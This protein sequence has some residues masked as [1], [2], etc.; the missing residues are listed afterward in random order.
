MVDLKKPPLV[1]HNEPLHILEPSSRET[2][3]AVPVTRVRDLI[4]VPE[5]LIEERKI[6][7]R[8]LKFTPAE[9]YHLEQALFLHKG[10]VAEL[11]AGRACVVFQQ[12][13]FGVQ[14]RGF[15]ALTDSRISGPAAYLDVEA[16]DVSAICLEKIE[17]GHMPLDGDFGGHVVV[18]VIAAVIYGCS[19]AYMFEITESRSLALFLG[20]LMALTAGYLVAKYGSGI[21]KWR[22][23]RAKKN[24]AECIV[25]EVELFLPDVIEQATASLE[26][27]Q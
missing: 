18:A 11:F 8:L 23:R 14:A 25:T 3:T 9:T 17:A 10:A 24:V 26:D 15:Y 4:A 2:A 16:P 27:G 21:W 19:M 6:S 7:G 20:G 5:G 22:G 13:R 1:D 12:T